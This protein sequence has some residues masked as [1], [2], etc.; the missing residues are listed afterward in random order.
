[1]QYTIEFEIAESGGYGYHKA[2]DKL[3]YPENRGIMCPRLLD[4]A[5]SMK[6]LSMPVRVWGDSRSL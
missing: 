4:S 2:G 3:K 1:V 6:S 5:S